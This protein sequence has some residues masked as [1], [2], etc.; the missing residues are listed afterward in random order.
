[1]A[2]VAG[3]YPRLDAVGLTVDAFEE[4]DQVKDST[5]VYWDIETIRPYYQGDSLVYY[6]CDLNKAEMFQAS[7]GTTT[8]SKSRGS[9]PRYRTK[10]WLETDSPNDIYRTSQIT[11]DDDSTAAAFGVIFNNPPYPLHLEFRGSSNMNGLIVIDQPT[12]T[13]LMDALTHAPYGYEESVPVHIVTVDST[14]CSGSA[15]A[16]KMEAELRHACETYP[17]GSLRGLDRRGKTDTNLGG[18]ILYDTEYT[19]NYKRSTSV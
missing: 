15:L 3:V 8:W 5:D 4:G 19:I 18:M 11:K 13:P 16:W 14:D 9:D 6:E 10:Y 1:M 7:F 2:L 17:T 12:V